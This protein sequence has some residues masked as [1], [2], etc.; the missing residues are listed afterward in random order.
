MLVEA[1]SV[2][3][4]SKSRATWGSSQAKNAVLLPMTTVHPAEPSGPGPLQPISQILG[5]AT[6][7]FAFGGSGIE[8]GREAP[9]GVEHGVRHGPEHRR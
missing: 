1:K 7:S 3:P 2:A 4:D 5:H 6:Q 8:F 9:C